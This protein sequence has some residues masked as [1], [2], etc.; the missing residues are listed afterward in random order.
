MAVFDPTEERLC[1]RVVYDGAASAGKTTNLRQL[2][3]L[4]ASQRTTEVISPA[5]LEGRTLYF[6]WMQIAAGA[7]CGFPLLCQVVSVPGQHAFRAR[8][9]S[10]LES[11]DVIVFVSDSADP[12]SEIHL[13]R[14]IE[15]ANRNIPVVVQAN[16]QDQPGAVDAK[17]LVAKI[18]G[19][20]GTP[21]ANVHIVEAIATDGIGVVDTFVSAVRAAARAVQARID[22]NDIYLE[23]RP[24]E[25][26]RA[27]LRRL[28]S[29][30]IDRESAA[31]LLLEEATHLYATYSI[32]PAPLPE[33]CSITILD[34]VAEEVAAP[35]PVETPITGEPV[36]A[37]LPRSNVPT[38]FVWPAHTGRTMLQAL[39]QALPPD[40]VLNSQGDGRFVC[41]DPH[42]RVLTTSF[43]DRFSDL[44]QARQALVRSAR[45]RTQ[46]QSLLVADTV[47]VVQPDPT[48]PAHSW[49]W[50]IIPQTTP[51]TEWLAAAMGDRAE[52]LAAALVDAVEIS[53]RHSLAFIANLA[54]FGVQSGI[55]RYIGLL[56]VAES[57]T[58]SAARLLH[59]CFNDLA[60][61]TSTNIR[62]LTVSLASRLEGRLRPGDLL[63]LGRAIAE[64]ATVNSS[65]MHLAHAII[66]RA[67]SIS[68][69]D[70]TAG[71][72][73]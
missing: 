51:V 31:E 27:L 49:L 69:T 5:E 12:D 23:I 45:E 1:V 33:A 35:P 43:S 71:A 61:R 42:N 19:G 62:D 2:A 6:D 18:G 41:A 54:S 63:R 16:K 30:E 10:L 46:L 48:S 47:L 13:R 65:A 40:T 64:I 34:S 22:R 37:P 44:D 73:A 38:G 4:F 59:G 55:V 32:L 3:S 53:F 20:G 72:A 28:A 50:M 9:Q 11:A 70:A 25:D 24:A 36:H 29:I 17:T 56:A 14:V 8:R 7:V 68:S 60:T 58:I 15:I 39:E 67:A 52:T 26:D 57:P 66:Q 21:P